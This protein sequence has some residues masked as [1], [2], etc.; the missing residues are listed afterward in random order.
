MGK[1]IVIFYILE[2]VVVLIFDL[3]FKFEFCFFRFNGIVVEIIVVINC[4]GIILNG[5]WWMLELGW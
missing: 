2:F 4:F 1:I 3:V 5:N